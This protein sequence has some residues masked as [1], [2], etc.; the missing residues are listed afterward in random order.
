MR[1][2]PGAAFCFD[3]WKRHL[4][5]EESDRI[6]DEIVGAEGA[7]NTQE[8]IHR[9]L[10]NVFCSLAHN[11]ISARNAAVLGYV[12]QLM[13]GS[14]P[15][16]ERTVKSLLP[17]LQLSTKAAY[18]KEK[19]SAM[20]GDRLRKHAIQELEVTNGMIDLFRTLK[21]MSA[22]EGLKFM[23]FAACFADKQEQKTEDKKKKGAPDAKS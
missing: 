18:Q 16:I 20:E 9:A 6:G 12:G 8:G 13:L 11:R 17:L 1:A 15:S 21:D 19:S 14:R 7:L 4:A 3:H 2:K 5:Q 23:Q 22:E 10:A